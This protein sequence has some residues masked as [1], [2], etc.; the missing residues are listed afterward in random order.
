[1]D[2]RLL[3]DNQFFKKVCEKSLCVR[4]FGMRLRKAKSSLTGLTIQESPALL[5]LIR[6]NTEIFINGIS[7]YAFFYSENIYL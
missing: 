2:K 3:T 1:M 6:I 5:N 7:I 4:N